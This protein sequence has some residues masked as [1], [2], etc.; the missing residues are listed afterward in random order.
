MQEEAH[1]IDKER[2][3][4][5]G[6]LRIL[7]AAALQRL[8]RT[9]AFTMHLCSL[10]MR[11]TSVGVTSGLISA[12][13]G[14]LEAPAWIEAPAMSGSYSA[15]GVV[16][17][18]GEA[19]D[20]WLRA[21][22][23]ARARLAEAIQSDVET[24]TELDV[25]ELAK[26]GKSE[27]SSYFYRTATVSTSIRLP[28]VEVPARW[29]DKRGK[30]FY[31]LARVP[32]EQVERV[33]EANYAAIARL[34]DEADLIRQGLRVDD[35]GGYIRET[36]HEC[37]LL[38]THLS[39][40]LLSDARRMKI[41][42]TIEG[43]VAELRRCFSNV[44]CE[45]SAPRRVVAR[46]QLT[47][48]ILATCSCDGKPMR[49]VTYQVGFVNGYGAVDD[50]VIGD[51]HGNLGFG[52]HRINSVSNRNEI[53]L[54]PDFYAGLETYARLAYPPIPGISMTIESVDPKDLARVRIVL[55]ETVRPVLSTEREEPV[56]MSALAGEIGKLLETRGF[57]V[58]GTST[59]RVSGG[60]PKHHELSE[61]GPEVT[62][63][64]RDV[65]LSAHV[66][67]RS[68]LGARRGGYHIVETLVTCSWATVAPRNR[69]CSSG[70]VQVRTVATEQETERKLQQ[71]L[72]RELM[73][74]I[75]PG[76][77]QCL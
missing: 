8:G 74:E 19:G 52:L 35:V 2:G 28:G 68:P 41:L 30:T 13:A 17:G 59:L 67:A 38:R 77:E 26:A 7:L 27:L 48:R 29:Y 53:A 57:R 24:R 15:V 60:P 25:A 16:S 58:A 51:S 1:Y 64:F 11:A 14:R 55:V 39:G 18:S 46:R 40:T 36:I 76:L 70:E 45:F 65:M 66:V 54:E 3:S 49:Q 44:T 42:G 37:E 43:L 21:E 71:E 50:V 6:P 31:C 75:E 34:V 47:E 56:E 32:V 72:Y 33:Q 73:G 63:G 22:E 61:L 10:T 4:G 62:E 9:S 12:C 20:D 5:R 23:A 69:T